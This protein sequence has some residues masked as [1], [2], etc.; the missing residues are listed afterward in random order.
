MILNTAD[1]VYSSIAN[2]AGDTWIQAGSALVNVTAE[3]R[4]Y[5]VPSTAGHASDAV[6]VTLVNPSTYRVL[7]VHEISGQLTS[8][9]LNTTATGTGTGTAF[10]TGS[11]T[12]VASEEIIIAA[13][14]LSTNGGPVIAGGSGYTLTNFGAVGDANMYYA[15]E[16]HIVTASETATATGNIS[17]QWGILAASFKTAAGASAPSGVARVIKQAVNRA[18]TY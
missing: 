15:D 17:A 5:Y 18:G 9:T 14:A 11:I 2:T 13:C 4:I 6:T 10:A 3:Y 12:V 8:G 16:W 7:V 1:A